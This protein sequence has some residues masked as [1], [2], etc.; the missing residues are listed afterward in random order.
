MT[1]DE[2]KYYYA[3]PTKPIK[4]ALEY[5]R[6]IFCEPPCHNQCPNLCLTHTTPNTLKAAY[7]IQ[8]HHI[9]PNI[10][11][12]NIHLMS[13]PLPEYPKPP[14]RIQHNHTQFTIQSIINN[15][16]HTYKNKHKIIKHYTSYLCQWILPNETKYHKWLP[17]R[18]LF[19]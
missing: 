17:Q 4:I 19:P 16:P 11:R 9:N 7:K 18:E 3:S 14:S 15:H 2:F 6:K 10:S 1:N 5:A 13:P 12:H 8:N